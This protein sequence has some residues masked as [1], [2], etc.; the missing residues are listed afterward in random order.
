M[1]VRSAIS[2]AFSI[3][4]LLGTLIALFVAL[5]WGVRRARGAFEKELVRQGMRKEDARRVSAHYSRLKN[6]IMG[7]VRNSIG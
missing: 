1:R 2:I 6:D 5:W 3:A 7:T 4:H